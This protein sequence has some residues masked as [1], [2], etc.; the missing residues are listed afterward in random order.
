MEEKIP[1]TEMKVNECGKVVELNGG[2]RTIRR[3]ENIGIRIGTEIR[4]INQ[5]PIKGPV[6]ISHK[7]TQVAIG[8][9][10]AKRIIVEVTRKAQNDKNNTFNG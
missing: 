2:P 4:K 7:N 9:S 6:I 3:L 1:L 8:F 5:Q 10:M